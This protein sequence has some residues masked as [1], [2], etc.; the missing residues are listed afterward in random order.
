MKIM[1]TQKKKLKILKKQIEPNLIKKIR[2][3]SKKIKLLLWIKKIIYKI[4]LSFYDD[5]FKWYNNTKFSDKN[6]EHNFICNVQNYF[7]Y[8]YRKDYNKIKKL[9]STFDSVKTRNTFIALNCVINTL[10]NDIKLLEAQIPEKLTNMITAENNKLN[11]YNESRKI[12]YAFLMKNK[13]I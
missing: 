9:F 3:S 2:I 11:F 12:I 6:T 7:V 10:K 4:M 1:T 13:L 8:I 5:S